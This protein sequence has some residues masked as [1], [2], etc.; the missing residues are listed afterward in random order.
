MIRYGGITARRPVMKQN[1]V[2]NVVVLEDGE[3]MKHSEPEQFVGQPDCTDWRAKAHELAK[4]EA[5]MRE[6]LKRCQTII[7]EL[8]GS[9]TDANWP[10]KIGTAAVGIIQALGMAGVPFLIYSGAFAALALGVLAIQ[11]IFGG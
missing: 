1:T 6:E 9:K 3:V 5:A 8:R 2:G 11:K 10:E 4:S 7:F